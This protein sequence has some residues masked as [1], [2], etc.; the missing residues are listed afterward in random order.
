MTEKQ[1]K[2][3]PTI[4]EIAAEYLGGE[5]L[6]NFLDFAAWLRANKMTPTFGSKSKT[7]ISYTTRVCYVKLF[8][9]AWYIWPAGK[10]G[11]YA[12]DFLACEELK[13]IVC[14]SLAKCTGCGHQCNSGA[15]FTKTVCGKEFEHICGCCPVR[16][17]I[18]DAETLK[19][20]KKTIEKRNNKCT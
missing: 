6:E 1:E 2:I 9:D 3:K 4:E 15:G 12:N 5:A 11:V 13:E 8:H 19:I 14:A 18:P 16:F 7:G 20:I 17:Y 10:Q